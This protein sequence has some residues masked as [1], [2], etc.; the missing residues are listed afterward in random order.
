V[1]FARVADNGHHVAN[2]DRDARQR[3]DV[4]INAEVIH[5]DKAHCHGDHQKC[6]D[7]KVTDQSK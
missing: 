7:R 6:G 1:V 3:H 5:H 2:G 4:A